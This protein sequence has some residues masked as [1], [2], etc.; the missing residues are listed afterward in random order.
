MFINQNTTIF[1]Y[2]FQCFH[3][4][5]Y[6]LI[7]SSILLGITYLSSIM[8]CSIYH[9]AV[10][11]IP[12]RRSVQISLRLWVWRAFPI[13]EVY[14]YTITNPMFLLL[15]VSLLYIL[16][17]VNMTLFPHI[18]WFVFLLLLHT[19]TNQNASV[20]VCVCVC[21]CICVCK[22]ITFLSVQ[23]EKK[24][25]FSKWIGLQRGL[26]FCK[27]CSFCS[28]IRVCFQFFAFVRFD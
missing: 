3:L 1:E 27:N 14:P 2:Y 16:F 7:W 28:Y 24:I 19:F 23:R 8:N 21:V 17:P 18:S 15:T 4:S 13:V 6:T 9:M 12:D 20:C 22:E 25:H 5:L 11:L 10:A 26:S